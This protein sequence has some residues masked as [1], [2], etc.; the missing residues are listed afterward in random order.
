[1]SDNQVHLESAFAIFLMEEVHLEI[2]FA[3]FL[4]EEIQNCL[5][6]FFD[7]GSSS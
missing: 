2:A 4:M 3:I 6:N 7:G 5:C 1:V